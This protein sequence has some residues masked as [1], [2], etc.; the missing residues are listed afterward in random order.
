MNRSLALPTWYPAP[1][2]YP[3]QATPATPRKGGA[4]R[5]AVQP[6]LS[7]L[8]IAPR[9]MSQPCSAE[10]TYRWW[11]QQVDEGS[12]PR[13]AVSR[14]APEFSGADGSPPTSAALA[15]DL[16]GRPEWVGT[17]RSRDPRRA[18]R[19]P[20]P[21]P[22]AHRAARRRHGPE[23]PASTRVSSG[24]PPSRRRGHGAHPR[25]GVACPLLVV[26]HD[27]ASDTPPSLRC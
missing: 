11:L 17:H 12:R 2:R 16:A 3:G 24:P 9:G 5:G 4:A 14:A 1:A 18:L 23:A 13:G 8:V 27:D 25:L 10:T 22:T 21:Y 7:A 26:V 19:A 6:Q 15:D 20:Q